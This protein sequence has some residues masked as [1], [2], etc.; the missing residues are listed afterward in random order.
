MTTHIANCGYSNLFTAGLFNI[1]RG[2]SAPSSDA[3]GCL[4]DQFRQTLPSPRVLLPAFDPSLDGSLQ[5]SSDA[6]SERRR[7]RPM[8]PALAKK[9][10][11]LSAGSVLLL[12][13]HWRSVKDPNSARS[14]LQLLSA[15]IDQ[16]GP[17]HSQQSGSRIKRYV[18]ARS[19][20]AKY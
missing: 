5:V 6:E 7:V 12:N 14:T 20:A 10:P 16:K 19:T 15:S 11:L 1:G 3:Q 4:L 13:G 2:W 17:C 8:I 18:P 9:S